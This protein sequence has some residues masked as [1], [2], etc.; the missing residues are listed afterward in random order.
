MKGI[1]K[2]D[3]LE[4]EDFRKARRLIELYYAK[5]VD[6]DDL[7]LLVADVLERFKMNLVENQNPEFYAFLIIC[8]AYLKETSYDEIR[9]LIT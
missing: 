2:F 8:K 6:N 5:F 1:R 7:K 3:F 9:H 4:F